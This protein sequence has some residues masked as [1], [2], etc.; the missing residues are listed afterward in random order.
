MASSR[1]E[2]SQSPSP[3]SRLEE[4]L[5]DTTS[6]I[7]ELSDSEEEEEYEDVETL[8]KEQLAN[9]A[10]L[11]SVKIPITDKLETESSKVQN[12]TLEQVL[13]FLEGNPNNFPLNSFGIPELQ[14]QLHVKFLKKALGDYPSPFEMMDASRPWIVYWSLQGLSALGYDISEFR[15]R[16]IHTF[17]LAQY[18]AGGYGG[19]FGHLPHLAATYAAVL[20]IVMVG[21]KDAYESIN[22]KAL[23]HFLGQL[24]QTDGGF[25]MTSGGEEDIRGAYCASVVLS[26]LNLPLELPE[27]AP[28][29][30]QGLTSFV[31]NLGEW[32]GKC[33][34]FDGGISAAPG[35]EA[36]GAYAFCGLGALTILGPPKETLNKYLDMPAL[37]HWLSARQCAPE[38]GYNGR[39]NKLVD[40]CY[41]HWVGGCWA[42]VA[43]AVT[44]P[45]AVKTL[46][47]R[48]AL[49]RYILS[50]AQFARG[51]LVDKPGKRPDAYHTCYNL[52]GLSAAQHVYE[53]DEE[54]EV[55]GLCA[56]YRWTTRGRY[57]GGVWGEGDVVG[58]VHPIFVVPFEAAHA[59]REYFE[60]KSEVVFRSQSL[61]ESPPTV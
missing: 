51:G 15:E 10:Y 41:S 44:S 29:R 6:R 11:E 58:E 19:N 24:K 25:N 45:A 38:G 20:S 53:Y 4:I 55:G 35:N 37:I 32:V 13:P 34:A 40:G 50:A 33:Q 5:D 54:K 21:G 9:M 43:A 1:P 42:L 36:H 48:D 17:S 3:S 27:D 52:A 61:S 26:L 30:Q 12:E 31:D 56:A 47:N 2:P 7:E 60:G 18:P 16:V 46:W 57:E 39:T 14:K 28:A 8:T 23:W 59:C 49:A 22:R